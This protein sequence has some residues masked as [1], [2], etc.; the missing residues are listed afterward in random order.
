MMTNKALGF[1][2]CL[3]KT[4]RFLKK[5]YQVGLF[6]FDEPEVFLS[7]VELRVAAREEVFFRQAAARVGD[8]FA[9]EVGSAL[10][11]FF[12]CVA[13][14]VTGSAEDEE[15]GDSSGLGEVG[16]GAG[17]FSGEGVEHFLRGVFDAGLAEEDCARVAYALRGFFAVDAAGHLPRELFLRAAQVRSLRVFV[18]QRLY[19]VELAEG[20]ELEELFKV[21]VVD[22]DPEL[23]ELVDA[24][25]LGR[26]VDGAAF[27]FAEFLSLR[28][29]QEREGDAVALPAGFFAREVHAR[30][31]VDLLVV[32]AHLE[33]AAVFVVEVVEVEGLEQDVGELGVGYRLVG[34]EDAAADVFA[35][36][37]EADGEVFSRVAQEFYVVFVFEPVVVVYEQR[38]VFAAVEVEEVAELVR[39]AGHVVEYLLFGEQ[40]ALG[41]FA[42]RVAYASR[43]AARYRDGAVS[44]ALEPRE[45]HYGDE[46][47]DVE[48]VRGRVEAYVA[49]DHVVFEVFFKLLVVARPLDEAAIP[50]NLQRVCVHRL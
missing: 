5:Y 12:L 25:T 26:E 43:A 32:A 28:V 11:D 50:Q 16:F 31:D 22:V 33:R 40:V 49:G 1:A 39:Y 18:E 4:K 47:A 37:E 24:G 15:V 30:D 45:S 35:V 19:L 46:V 41:A 36:D 8:F 6:E 21:L 2:L 42:G 20:E 44:E 29:E 10:F 48:A 27:G 34:V 13:L 38:A 17:D 14:G 3:M 9:V 23:V 7:D